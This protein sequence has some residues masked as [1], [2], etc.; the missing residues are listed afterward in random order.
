VLGV[1]AL[2]GLALVLLSFVFGMNLA[3]FGAP[4]SIVFGLWWHIHRITSPRHREYRRRH[5]ELTNAE[6]ALRGGEQHWQR[7]VADRRS[8]ESLVRK[9]LD[10]VFEQCWQL[11]KKFQGEGQD[12]EKNREAMLREQH[13]RNCFITDADIPGIGTTRE[14][15]LASFGIETAFDIEPGPIDM[16]KGFG[17]VLTGNLMAWKKRMIK[18]FR[19]DPTKRVPEAEL[20]TLALKYQQLQDSLFAHLE[21]GAVEL[22]SLART[23]QHE[24][25]AREPELRRLAVVWAQAK[26]DIQ[27][28]AGWRRGG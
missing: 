25:Q 3:L 9:N 18:E 12:L 20:R 16:I 23:V 7:F 15:L 6:S 27:V 28:L 22:E 5:A 17:K 21:R 10:R 19:Y 2:G 1:V 24:Q 14:Q 4:V 8:H 26:A 13:L 11:E